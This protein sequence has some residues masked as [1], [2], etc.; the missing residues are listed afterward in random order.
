MCLVLEPL[1]ECS[2]DY[3][4]FGFRKSK[5]PKIAVGV[6]RGIFKIINDEYLKYS[7]L[8]QQKKEIRI[9]KHEVKW[10]LNGDIESFFNN[11]SHEYLLKNL[12]LSGV[13]LIFVKN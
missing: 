4:S 6:V 11:I 10:V 3:N 5:G 2:S 13:G 8:R 1:V 7:F 12:F 9:V